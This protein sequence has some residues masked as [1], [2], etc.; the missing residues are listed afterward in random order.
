[1]VLNIYASNTPVRPYEGAPYLLRPA[2][3]EGDLPPH[4][5]GWSWRAPK[6]RLLD[7]GLVGAHR[8]DKIVK[9]IAEHGFY[10]LD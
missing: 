6:V 10:I 2:E 3:A 1:M 8:P 7:R 9:A 4:P 5:K